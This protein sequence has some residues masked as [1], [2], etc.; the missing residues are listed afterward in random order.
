MKLRADEQAAPQEVVIREYPYSSRWMDG[1]KLMGVGNL[2]LTNKRLA[3]VNRL[4]LTKEE[5]ET[6]QKLAT[7][8]TT[9]EMIDFAL[10]L[11][12]INFQI[13]LS[14]VVSV[15]TSL[16]SILPFPRPCLSISYQT[17]KTIVQTISFMFTIPLW[18]A[19][20]QFEISTIKI[21]ERFIKEALNRR[22]LTTGKRQTKKTSKNK[23]ST[24]QK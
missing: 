16:Y 23:V 7:T 18:K 9:S 20:F 8:A 14:S 21:W 3:F 6:L 17:K 10:T 24:A 2:I 22:Q 5:A 11:H 19:W 15:K 1:Q 13:P 12:K 4:P